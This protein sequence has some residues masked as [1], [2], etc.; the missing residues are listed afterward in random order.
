MF[1]IVTKVKISHYFCPIKFRKFFLYN[2]LYKI[3]VILMD[4]LLKVS[5]LSC[6]EVKKN[7]VYTVSESNTALFR[8]L[9]FIDT[10]KDITRDDT[11]IFLIVLTT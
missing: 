9:F 3:Y 11:S 1:R 6:Y 10:S 5:L 8:G 7:I 2:E 4:V